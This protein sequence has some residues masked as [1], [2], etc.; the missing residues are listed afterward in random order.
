MLISYNINRLR[1]KKIDQI[2]VYKLIYFII[3]Y[4]YLKIMIYHK[5]C[6][7]CKQIKQDIFFSKNNN[8]KD[9]LSSC[10]KEC[11]KKRHEENKNINIIITKKI[12]TKCKIEKDVSYFC[13]NIT[14]INGYKSC[15]K[16]CDKKFRLNNKEKLSNKNKEWYIKNKIKIR[17]HAN[18]YY[19]EVYY[20]NNKEKII[21]KSVIQNKKK[22]DSDINYRIC[23]HVSSRIREQLGENK[24]F[25]RTKYIL[26]YSIDEL[27]KHLENLFEEGMS[28]N[29]YGNKEGYWNID[30]I[31]P[32]SSFNIEN[33][34][35]N[36]FKE[37]WSLNNLQPMWW[38]DNVRKGNRYV[39]K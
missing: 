15:C 2:K 5:K 38:K 29:N 34:E 26:G 25:K 24:R 31:R 8:S 30:H 37:C 33:L 23:H 32:I 11:D 7:K 9:K 20:P 36:D 17:E 27:I 14:N 13:K 6:S 10:C 3:T 28:W 1:L 16:D 4:W 19:K 22:Y 39:K 12:C 35:D 21:K 18:K